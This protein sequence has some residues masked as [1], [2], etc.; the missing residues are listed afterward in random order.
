MKLCDGI[1]TRI[2]F[3]LDD[4]LRNGELAGFEEHLKSCNSCA[5]LV[6]GERRFLEF[7]RQSR[8]LYPAPPELRAAP[9]KRAVTLRLIGSG[10]LRRRFRFDMRATHGPFK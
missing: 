1:R 3:Y 2:A 4:E 7:V 8:P 9:R 5:D 10:E 6:A